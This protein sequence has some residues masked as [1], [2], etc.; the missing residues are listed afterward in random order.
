MVSII[1][2]SYFNRYMNYATEPYTHTGIV[3]CYQTNSCASWLPMFLRVDTWS[4]IER[5]YLKGYSYKLC[6]GYTL[7]IFAVVLLP[8]V[9]TDPISVTYACTYVI[10]KIINLRAE[11][12]CLYN[13]IS[14]YLQNYV[15]MTTRTFHFSHSLKDMTDKH[16]LIRMS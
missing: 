7:A 6:A 12:K 5:T 3:L 10:K 16:Y 8:A 11:T 14:W 13:H 2:N 4:H 9:M 1:L 15:A